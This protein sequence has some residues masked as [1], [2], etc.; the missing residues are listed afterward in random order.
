MTAARTVWLT[1]GSSG[2]GATLCARS[3]SAAAPS[4]ASGARNAAARHGLIAVELVPAP[5]SRRCAREISADPVAPECPQA[6]LVTRSAQIE[7]GSLDIHLD[8]AWEC[9]GDRNLDPCPWPRERLKR[10][11]EYRCGVES[12]DSDTIEHDS[13]RLPWADRQA[14]E[15]ARCASAGVNL[16]HPSRST[17]GHRCVK[18]S[19]RVLECDLRIHEDIEIPILVDVDDFVTDI[20]QAKRRGSDKDRW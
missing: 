2:I 1:G 8:S 17:L 13:C 20:D 6:H 14:R 7:V 5:Q 15:A 10:R 3:A 11:Q 12:Q 4:V 19:R 18:S 16:S 9:R